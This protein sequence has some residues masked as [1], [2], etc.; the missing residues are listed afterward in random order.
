MDNAKHHRKFRQFS[1][2]CTMIIRKHWN[3]FRDKFLFF[4]LRKKT[5]IK[6]IRFDVFT[7]LINEFHIA[8]MHNC[9][10]MLPSDEVVVISGELL[11]DPWGVAKGWLIRI[12]KLDFA[13]VTDWIEL[14]RVQQ[15]RLEIQECERRRNVYN[16]CTMVSFFSR[17]KHFFVF[18]FCVKRN[19]FSVKLLLW[20]SLIFSVLIFRW[21][22]WY[23]ITAW[24]YDNDGTKGR[25]SQE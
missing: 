25:G 8:E 20:Q 21:P 17:R 15:I 4:F 9:L 1:K 23:F 16:F 2:L 18:F 5:C 10:L 11:R 24:V 14:G 19:V 12:L 22:F 7:L 13:T 6:F 3:V